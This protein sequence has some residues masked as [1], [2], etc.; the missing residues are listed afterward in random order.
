MTLQAFEEHLQLRL[1]WECHVPTHGCHL[2]QRQCPACRRKW[3]YQRLTRLWESALCFAE[4]IPPRRAAQVTGTS[5]KTALLRYWR[6]VRALRL[7]RPELIPHAGYPPKKHCLARQDPMKRQRIIEVLLAAVF[8]RSGRSS[9]DASRQ[10]TC[11]VS[12]LKPWS[13][14]MPTPDNCQDAERQLLQRR[15]RHG[16]G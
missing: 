5:Y 11:T 9:F 10:S 14:G 15:S 6:F 3:S 7:T 2:H 16:H 8:P 4:G 1:C 13:A 12:F